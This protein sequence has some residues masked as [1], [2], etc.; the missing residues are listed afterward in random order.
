MFPFYTPWK[1]QKT[2]ASQLFVNQV[3]TSNKPF[4]REQEVKAKSF[5]NVFRIK[6]AWSLSNDKVV[7]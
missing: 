7:I 6:R 1:Y 4:L 3:V 2:S 5:K